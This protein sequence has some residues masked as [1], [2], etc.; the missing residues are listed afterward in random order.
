MRFELFAKFGVGGSKPGVTGHIYP[1]IQGQWLNLYFFENGEWRK[2]LFFDLYYEFLRYCRF[3]P[4]PMLQVH[5]V[6]AKFDFPYCAH[7]YSTDSLRFA[8]TVRR[9]GNRLLQDED[10]D[11]QELLPSL[12]SDLSSLSFLPYELPVSLLSRVVLQL[13]LFNFYLRR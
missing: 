6:T 5:R 10:V 12:G 13:V 8:W 2:F 7:E 4:L 3:C 9:K 11:E 1:E